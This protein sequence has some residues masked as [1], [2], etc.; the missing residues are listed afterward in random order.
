M[1]DAQNK[2]TTLYSYQSGIGANT[3]AIL[4]R[5][6]RHI[7]YGDLYDGGG[8]G[9]GGNGG[10]G[11]GGGEIPSNEM[12]FTTLAG[13]VDYVGT[14]GDRILLSDNSIVYITATGVT[15]TFDAPSGRHVVT[16]VESVGRSSYVSVGGEALVELHNFPALSTVTSFNFATYNY[17][18][19][20]NLTKVPDFLPS[21]I[22]NM[23]FM[24]SNASAF[25]QPL[26]NWNVSSVTNMSFMFY[27]ASV[28]NQDLSKWCVSNFSTMP[29]NFNYGANLLT[30]AKLPI[31]GT[32][33][34]P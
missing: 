29:Y 3:E 20:P 9:G 15:V 13:S 16:L 5:T 24:F 6:L 28:F 30:G 33:P 8:N 4:N 18:P 14:E 26:N 19:L 27:E 21:N 22:T 12:H 7:L 11:N 1:I 2:T 10:G 32:C 17:N 34:A 25:N 31:W 23:N